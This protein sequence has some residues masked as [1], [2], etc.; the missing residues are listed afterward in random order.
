ML[1]FLALFI[2]IRLIK[3][4][5]TQKQSLEHINNGSTVLNFNKFILHEIVFVPIRACLHAP[6]LAHTWGHTH[7]HTPFSRKFCA[8]CL[9]YSYQGIKNNIWATTAYLNSSISGVLQGS[10]YTISPHLSNRK[11]WVMSETSLYPNLRSVINIE[12]LLLLK[13]LISNLWYPLALW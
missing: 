13:S 9:I 11:V 4:T 6:S 7:I 8:L 12:I 1:K 3:R 2:E 10:V 5:Q